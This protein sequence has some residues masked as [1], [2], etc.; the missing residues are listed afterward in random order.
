MQGTNWGLRPHIQKILYLTVISSIVNYGAAIWAETITE[1][2]KRKLFAVQRPFLL[3][4]CKAY[5]TIANS[6]LCVLTGIP[7]LHL[8]PTKDSIKARVLQLKED[9][10]LNGTTIFASN[11]ESPAIPLTYHHAKYCNLIINTDAS[12]ISSKEC[13]R[14]F[15]D[16][17]KIH[18]EVG[19]E[20][21]IYSSSSIPTVWQ[22]KLSPENSVYQAELSAIQS[23][24]NKAISNNF[25]TIAIYSGSQSAL[26]ALKDRNNKNQLVQDIQNTVSAHPEIQFILNWVKAPNGNDGNEAADFLAKDA[27]TNIKSEVI[28]VPW[29][30][31]HLKYTLNAIVDSKW[32]EE[33]D[34]SLQG[35]RVHDF[36]LKKDLTKRH[37]TMNIF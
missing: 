27:T 9:A 30:K 25:R 17:S 10:Y 5:R 4:I 22:G 26:Y 20:S 34:S 12:A 1:K 36:F 8:I 11:Y 15:T 24:V 13:P 6:F 28:H 16:G 32:Q 23:A 29:P 37:Y 14:A 2:K 19:A 31:S 7:D 18:G 33:W 3:S 21:I 35:R